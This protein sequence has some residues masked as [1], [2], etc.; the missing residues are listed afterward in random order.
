[1]NKLFFLLRR[2][3]VHRIR[4]VFEL[5]ENGE[6]IIDVACG[7][8]DF[9]L[10]AS[11]YF[12]EV[13]GVDIS[14]EKISKAK[15]QAKDENIKN[16]IF[17]IYDVN[18]GL[19]F[20]KEYFNA[21]TAIAALAFFFDPYFI[22]SEFRRILKKGGVLIV[23]VPNLAYLPRRITLLLG[24]LPK[25]ASTDIGWDGGHLHNFTQNSLVKLIE[26]SG[27]RVLKITGS[28]IFANLR[29]FWPSL[30]CGNIIVKA[31]KK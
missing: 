22:M 27:F 20:K 4:A 1:M 13:Y 5:L 19:K 16:V 21:V 6:R 11:K 3:E 7:S 23:E 2:F 31:V 10:L 12:K 18:G 29:N 28:G 25:V 8:G 30:L 9:A 24:H 15:K 14:S 17:D 26:N